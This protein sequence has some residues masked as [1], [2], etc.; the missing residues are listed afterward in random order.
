MSGA[1]AVPGG[2]LPSGRLPGGRLPGG[3][4]GQ[5]LALGL[6]ALL[7]GVLAVGVV[8]PLLDWYG[9]RAETLRR[10]V[11]IAARMQ[12]IAGSLPAVQR[13]AQAA[14][15]NG[16][17]PKSV[18][19]GASDAV[20]GA[21]LQGQIDAMARAD[22]AGLSSSEALPAERAGDYRR[23]GVHLSLSAPLP[24]LVALLRSIA[25][26]TPRM[27]ADDLQ[28]QG[29]PLLARATSLPLDA[30]F[31]VFAFRTGHADAKAP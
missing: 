30:S 6:L 1:R 10:E 12:V 22:G 15:A 25:T 20:D 14:A 16:P 18:Y 21:A 19:D 27:L 2:A 5:L 29:S 13:E 9:E 28:L 24:V 7:L 31:T 17:P 3:R 26:A 8:G 4:N 11:A 23:I